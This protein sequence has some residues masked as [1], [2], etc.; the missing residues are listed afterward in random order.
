MVVDS[1]R[2]ELYLA[3]Y[4][5]SATEVA[6]RGGPRI[7]KPVDVAHGGSILG[8]HAK[9]WFP[10]ALDVFPEASFVAELARDPATERPVDALEPVYL[11]EKSFVKAPPP[12]IA[13]ALSPS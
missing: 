5:I 10:T 12:R 6:L 4:E 9:R 8:P 7:V 3:E 2:G 1:Q 11:R 13:G